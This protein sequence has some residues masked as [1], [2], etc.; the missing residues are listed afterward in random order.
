MIFVYN[1]LFMQMEE[2]HT[3]ANSQLMTARFAQP[4][5]TASRF[6]FSSRTVS[7]HFSLLKTNGCLFCAAKSGK[8]DLLC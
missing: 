7:C 8:L 3:N 2:F 4:A 5:T 1:V 6:V